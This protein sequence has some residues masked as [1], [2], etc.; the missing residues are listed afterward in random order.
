MEHSKK[1]A[2]VKKYYDKGLWSEYRVSEAVVK[3]W[4]TPEEYEE[5]VGKPYESEEQICQE[6]RLR[7]YY[8]INNNGK[9]TLTKNFSF[10]KK[11]DF[12]MTQNSQEQRI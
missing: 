1:F 11:Y 5:I 8:A 3:E 2:T 6:E 9:V 12:Y 7:K 4:I 10:Q